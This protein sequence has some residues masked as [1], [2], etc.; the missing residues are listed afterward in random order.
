M[1]QWPV[2]SFFKAPHA[3]IAGPS[4]LT[5][6]HR[7]PDGAVGGAAG[8]EAADRQR[9]GL[10]AQELS[11]SPLRCCADDAKGEG[12]SLYY[13]LNIFIITFPPGISVGAAHRVP[14]LPPGSGPSRQH[15]T[16][17]P[18]LINAEAILNGLFADAKGL[19]QPELEEAFEIAG[20]LPELLRLLE[21][22]FT[23]KCVYFES[24]GP[25]FDTRVNQRLESD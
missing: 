16:W 20:H 23:K 2:L 1:R 14:A 19:S 6:V 24:R 4:L 17:H 5:G 21:G 8:E 18:Y 11:A 9:R 22:T 3:S 10:P 15:K 7:V 25:L 12:I 13:I